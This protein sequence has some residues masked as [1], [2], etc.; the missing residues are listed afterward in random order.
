MNQ[1]LWQHLRLSSSVIMT[2]ASL[3]RLCHIIDEVCRSVAKMFNEPFIGR[4]S[5]F[6]KVAIKILASNKQLPTT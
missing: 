4:D 3:H 5:V 1:K 2:Q 6:G